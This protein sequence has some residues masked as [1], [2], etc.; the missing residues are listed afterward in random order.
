MG[1]EFATIKESG[2]AHIPDYLSFEQAASVLLTA[3]TAMQDFELMNVKSGDSVFISGGTGSL[4]AMVIPIAKKLG[5]RVFTNGSGDHKERVKKLGAE[6]FIDYR[7]ENDVDVLSNV[8]H[9]LDTIGGRELPNE[10]KVLK[11]GGNLVS[12]RG[13][14]NGRFAVRYDMPLSR[15]ILFRLAGSK[16]DRMA[17][18]KNQ[19]YDF[20]F[21]H[22]D[23][24]KME[25]IG[26]MF[27]KEH[28]LETSVDTIFRLDEINEALEK[29]KQGKSRGKTIITV[30][31]Y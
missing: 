5:L 14:P 22:E 9:V 19:T 23:G 10:C 16:Y 31:E 28:P 13:I 7:K 8:D 24:S 1:N 30:G 15:K 11:K 6:K 4:G 12:L 25:K 21:V 27:D 29:V 17:A 18:M 20:L 3:L 2:L 26:S